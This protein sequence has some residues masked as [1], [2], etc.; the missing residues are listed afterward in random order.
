[1]K[2]AL[3]I[4]RNG[5]ETEKSFYDYKF[6]STFL[7]SRRYFSYLLAI[8]TLASL[9]PA[10]HEIRVFDENI[11]EIDYDWPAD[12]VGISVRTM[13]AMR[14]YEIADEWRRRGKKA[15]LGGIHPSMC[16]EEALAH[17]DAVVIGEAEKVWAGLLKDA[18]SGRLQRTYRGE[19]QFDLTGSPKPG[20]DVLT[21]K[22]YFSD[23]VQ[24][25]KGCPFH[26]EF[27]SVHAYDGTKIRN[28]TVA[29]VVSEIIDVGGTSAGYKKKSI[30]FAD[31][32]IIANRKFAKELFTALKPYN[33]NWSCQA[34]IN[35]SQDDE[36]LRLMKE[37]GCGAILIGLESVSDKNLSQMQK[38]VNLKHD[39]VGAIKKIQA[40]GILVHSS[41]I[42][43][44]DFDTK[45]SFGELADFIDE[46]NLLMPLINI[47][48]PF[49]GTKLFARLE[50]EGRILHKDWSRYDA[51]SVVYKPT[52]LTPDELL[53][54]YRSVIRRVY[55]F[56][57]IY[58]KLKRYWET[59]FWRRSNETDPIRFKYRLL[60]AAR[61]VSLAF[62]TNLKRTAFILKV[63]PR[64]FD[65]RVR[66]STILTLMAYND[67]AYA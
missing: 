60:F 1:M 41:F 25:T 48:T 7:F 36:M 67:Y 59:D 11:E 39:Y 5:N 51:K 28:K 54:G 49:P 12:L 19:G 42:L 35:V 18:E 47:L 55:S 15:V 16:T 46:A 29:Q 17:A 33:L 62:S 13:F 6:Y 38:G 20:R 21:R 3:I 45:E 53:E 37:S 64:V 56:D 50:A 63:L 34:S 22:M 66:V 30:F 61:L 2:I 40:H 65:S 10:G 27:C 43:G 4:P 52:L 58:A 23:I 8:P 32:N 24:T 44:Y 26:C 57:S 14:A 9:T 31:D